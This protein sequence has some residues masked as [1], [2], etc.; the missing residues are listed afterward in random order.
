VSDGEGAPAEPGAN[1]P[2]SGERWATLAAGLQDVLGEVADLRERLDGLLRPADP[3]NPDDTGG[4]ITRLRHAVTLLAEDVATLLRDTETL[5]S[6]PCWVD[7]DAE[8]ADAAWERLRDW[9]RD[10]LL[11]R[12]P[13]ITERRLLPPCWYRHPEA[14]ERLSWLHV[15]WCHAYRNPDLPPTAAA[16]WHVRWLAS[17][18]TW[19]KDHLSSCGDGHDEHD[20][21]AAPAPA[22]DGGFAAFVSADVAARPRREEQIDAP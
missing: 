18:L 7:L 12:Y 13:R 3:V 17:L 1:G 15:T 9:V 19:S 2:R 14:V 22:V 16:E 11:V 5:P 10:V 21:S 8:A 6:L 20:D 4:E